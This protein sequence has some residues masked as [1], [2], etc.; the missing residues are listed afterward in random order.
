MRRALFFIAT[1]IEA[2]R[3]GLNLAT[4][5]REAR[6]MI[7]KR[8]LDATEAGERD[9]DRLKE[10]ALAAAHGLARE[11]QAENLTLHPDAL[12]RPFVRSRQSRG[13]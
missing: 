2:R 5:D 12:R 3:R 11:R 1:L 9:I 8:L 4:T 6:L 13:S 10:L 7:A